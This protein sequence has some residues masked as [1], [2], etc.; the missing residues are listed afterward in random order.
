MRA[1]PFDIDDLWL[2][3]ESFTRTRATA[4]P[5]HRRRAFTTNRVDAFA[6]I[7]T[8]RT[9]IGDPCGSLPLAHAQAIDHDSDS[10]AIA[11][12][13][14]IATSRT[15]TRRKRQREQVTPRRF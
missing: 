5:S 13:R 9:A 4:T 6:R 1:S 14:A 8:R 12:T 15:A 3:L 10:D 7:Q 2:P 11:P